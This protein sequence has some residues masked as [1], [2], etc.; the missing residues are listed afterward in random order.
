MANTSSNDKEP[1]DK[2]NTNESNNSG[3][4]ISTMVWCTTFPPTFHILVYLLHYASLM[5]DLDAKNERPP[6]II[7]ERGVKDL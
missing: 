7:R 4:Q 6:R 3:M 2:D 5:V 1:E